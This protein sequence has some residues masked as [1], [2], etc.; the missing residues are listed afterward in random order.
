MIPKLQGKPM[1]LILSLEAGTLIGLIFGSTL[2]RYHDPFHHRDT[3]ISS[4]AGLT[5]SLMA[6]TWG[7]V[8]AGFGAAAAVTTTFVTLD[9]PKQT[10]HKLLIRLVFSI[11][12]GAIG[13]G[14]THTLK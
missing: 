13:L 5:I 14:L 10:V 4:I 11:L 3:I 8:P 1:G 12:F 7:A 9:N 6:Y 2:D